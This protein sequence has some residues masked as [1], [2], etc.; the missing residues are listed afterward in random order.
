MTT[1]IKLNK[2]DLEAYSIAYDN[3]LKEVNKI[4]TSNWIVRRLERMDW[5]RK[6]EAS[7]FK[8]IIKLLMK[9]LR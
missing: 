7:R 4:E 1:L 3:Y 8:K 6:M 9:G 2:K 5:R